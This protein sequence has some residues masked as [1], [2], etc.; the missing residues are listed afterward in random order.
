MATLLNG[1]H[2]FFN[3]GE[4]AALMGPS[5][6]GKT[7]LLDILSGR[8]TQGKVEGTLQFGGQK[9]TAAFLKRYT[10]QLQAL[11]AAPPAPARRRPAAAA[12]APCPRPPSPPPPSPR[13][14][15]PAA[16]PASPLHR[17]RGRGAV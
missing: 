8:K 15:H 10:G 5:G 11:A 7:T 6:S 2:G 13:R 17:D 16:C 1:V 3:P 9:P 14:A 12:H 4:M